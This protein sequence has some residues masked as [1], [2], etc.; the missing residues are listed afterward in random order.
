[1]TSAHAQGL[2]DPCFYS[3]PIAQNFAAS[4]DITGAPLGTADGIKYQNG[5][6]EGTSGTGVSIAPPIDCDVVNAVFLRNS[7]GEAQG[8]GF[9]LNGALTAGNQVSFEYTYISH[10]QGS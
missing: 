2:A 9:R 1:M 8:V 4:G 3:L 10:G 6:W 5:S 7:G